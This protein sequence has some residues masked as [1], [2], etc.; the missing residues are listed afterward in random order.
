MIN[1]Q[2]MGKSAGGKSAARDGGSGRD[3]NSVQTFDGRS[4]LGSGDGG[5]Q[6][7]DPG[8]GAGQVKTDS[9]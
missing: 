1:K 3:G 8:P 5:K 6:P 7:V 2:K 9:E 4:N